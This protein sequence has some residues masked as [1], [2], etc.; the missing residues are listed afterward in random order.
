[1]H[2]DLHVRNGCASR[3]LD[4]PD[5]RTAADLGGQG[6]A[7]ATTSMASEN[8]SLILSDIQSPFVIGA[9]DLGSRLKSIIYY[10]IDNM[11]D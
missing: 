7:A 11:N 3:V 2:R 8:N 1:M 10:I 6:V 9:H 4:R 5:D